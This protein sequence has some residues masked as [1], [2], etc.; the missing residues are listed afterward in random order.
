MVGDRPWREVFS[1]LDRQ[2]SLYTGFTGKGDRAVRGFD[3]ACQFTFLAVE[4]S[5]AFV[6]KPKA[7]V[8]L[9]FPTFM[10]F[11]IVSW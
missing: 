11:L 2:V 7:D 9:Y 5:I 6:F 1:V 4:P 10:V 3:I 8:I